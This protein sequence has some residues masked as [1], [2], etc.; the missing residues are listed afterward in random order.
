MKTFRKVI[1]LMVIFSIVFASFTFVEAASVTIAAPK[2]KTVKSIND[3][4]VQI[5]WSKVSGATG[6]EMYRAKS[7]AGKYTKVGS[8]KTKLYFNDNTVCNNTRYYYK[9]RAVK[10]LK[11]KKYR[12]KY[13]SSKSAKCNFKGILKI[14]Q[15]PVSLAVGGTAILKFEE[16][17]ANMLDICFEYDSDYLRV[18]SQS[19]IYDDYLSESIDEKSISISP[20]KSGGTP[21]D[22][23]LKVYF[24]D[25]PKL[26]STKITVKV[27]DEGGVIM[28]DGGYSFSGKKSYEG[29]KA[30]DLGS[31]YRTAP[32]FAEI[33][34]YDGNRFKEYAYKV[35]DIMSNNTLY[36]ENN[37]LEIYYQ[38]MTDRVFNLISSYNEGNIEVNTY[39]RNDE[40]VT[41]YT[42]TNYKTIVV[43]VFKGFR[44]PYIR[45]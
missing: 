45:N 2:I 36:S 20:I 31:L 8:T 23:T 21:D 13:S 7:A 38:Q 16:E 30:I 41:T 35:D 19:S 12:S 1:S 34:L 39:Q 4:H 24:A 44:S 40:Y 17:P 10:E 33:C 6:Y 32:E 14:E 28:N 22:Y 26:I 11:G 25:Y 43:L 15:K 42:S 37:I 18:D 9:V 27:T 5:S 3:T 29:T